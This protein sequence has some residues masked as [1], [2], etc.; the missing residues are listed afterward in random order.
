[1]TFLPRH[2]GFV[3]DGDVLVFAGQRAK[4]EELVAA[5]TS[6]GFKAGAIHGDMDQV[7]GR[8][9][10]SAG[11]SGGGGGGGLGAAAILPRRLARLA[12]RRHANLLF[13]LLHART[14][15]IPFIGICRR[16][17]I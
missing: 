15:M 1:V 13:A 8:G 5:L 3:D 4:V 14:M 12:C 9:W 17:P 10:L 2:Q 6:A 11:C 16:R 7:G